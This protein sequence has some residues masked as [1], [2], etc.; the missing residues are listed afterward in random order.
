[1]NKGYVHVLTGN[2]KGKTTAAIGLSIRA[3]GAGMKIFF[4]QFVK[5]GEFSEI[6]ALKRFDDLITVE[7]FGLDRFTNKKPDLEDI[8]AARRG[9]ERVKQVIA[10]GRYD[11]VILD[12]AN[13]AVEFG[14][15]PMQE[16]L[17]IIINKPYA[18]ELVITG[19]YAS[20][21]IMEMADMVTELQAKKHYY[22]HGTEARTGIEK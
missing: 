9:L 21:R 5:K 1:M 10:S 17:G 18:L 4:G 6:K 3:A 19:R 8:Q 14:L 13:V 22:E 2:G 15:F 12:E 20:P 16:L 11:M 7:Q